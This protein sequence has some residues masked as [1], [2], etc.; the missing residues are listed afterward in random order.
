MQARWW[1]IL[2]IIGWTYCFCA[3]VYLLL[4]K[5]PL[6][7]V[8]IWIALCVLNLLVT[9][10]RGGEQVLSG[11]FL[12]TDLT[13]VLKLGNGCFAI[14]A[15]G[16]MLLPL[17]ENHQSSNSGGLR[18]CCAACLA[19]V[20]AAA[21]VILHHWW[22]VSKLL[23]T[24]P[25]C[26]YV[27]SL[28]VVLYMLL[29]TLEARGWTAWFRPLNA[30]GTATLTVYMMPYVLYSVN[31]FLGIYEYGSLAGAL[32]LFKCA[33]FSLLCVGVTSLLVRL[34]IKLKL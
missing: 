18:I 16:G 20:L 21:G 8:L 2:G 15:V 32:G 25:W 28:S 7:M 12:L 14:M 3:V 27:S 13:G 31:D 24:L 26:L 1:G 22:T 9:K 19:V 23:G 4:R 10:M 6:R 17:A 30:S 29:R 5:K 33:A 34:G 11:Q